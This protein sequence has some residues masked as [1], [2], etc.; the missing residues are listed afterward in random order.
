MN[1]TPLKQIAL[2]FVISLAGGL[3]AHAQNFTVESVGSVRKYLTAT[4]TETQVHVVFSKPVSSVTGPVAGN[5][6]ISGGVTVTAAQLIT[7][8]PAA[9]LQDVAQNPTPFGR[10]FD[11]E[12]VLL[13]VTGLAADATASITITGVT[14]EAGDALPTTVVNFK[15]SGYTWVDVGVHSI[16][17][18]VIAVSTNGFDV[19]SSGGTQWSDEDQVTLVY[20]NVTGD[21]DINARVEFQDFSSRWGRA[22]LMAREVLNAAEDGATQDTTASRYANAHANPARCW[23]DTATAGLVTA[24]NQFESHFREIQGGE[25]GSAAGG[26]PLFPDAWVR[27]QRTGETIITHR[28]DNGTDW[29][30]MAQRQVSDPGPWN[31]SLF[32]GFGYAP[33]IGNINAANPADAKNRLFLA[34]YRFGKIPFPSSRFD[35]NPTGLMITVT[36]AETAADPATAVLKING[37]TVTASAS[38][39]GNITTVSYTQPN[40]FVVG[41]TNLAELTINTTTGLPVRTQSSWVAAYGVI[42]ASYALA[43]PATGPGMN[44][45]THLLDTTPRSPG[46]QNNS[47]AAEQQILGGYIDPTTGLPY[48][49]L[50]SPASGA[51]PTGVV[52]WEQFGGDIDVTPEDGPDNFNTMRPT[53][54]PIPNDLTPGVSSIDPNW[55][56]VEVLT[57]L[58][59]S[60]GAYRMGVNSDDGFLVSAGLDAADRFGVPLGIFNAG[61]GASDTTFDFYVSANG[62]YPFRLL[63]WEGNGGASAEW[64]AVNLTTGEKTLINGVPAGAVKAYQTGAGRAHVKS[65]LPGNGFTGV[66]ATPT[67]K[68]DFANGTTSVKA[69]SVSL[70]VDGNTVLSAQSGPS[71]SWTSP[72]ALGYATTHSGSIIWTE[73]TVPETVWTNNFTFAIQPFTPDVLPPG[74][75]W[76]ESEDYNYGSGQTVAA[77][78]VMP[79]TGDAYSGLEGVV[80]VDFNDVVV[81][82]GGI[83][84]YRKPFDATSQTIPVA[85]NTAGRFGVDRPGTVDMVTNYKIGWIGSGD[86]YN[87][88]RT[89]PPGTYNAFAALS[90]DAGTM[91]ARLELVT[92]PANVPNQTLQVLGTF[93]GP[94]SGAWSENNLLAMQAPDGSPAVFKIRGAAPTTFRFNGISGDID[95][96]VVSPAQGVP[97]KVT[98]AT[99]A[100]GAA[101]PRDSS[102]SF[103]IEDFTTTVAPANVRLFLDNVNVTS[104]ATIQKPA[105]IMTITYAPGQM[106]VGSHTYRLEFTDSATVTRT[107]EATFTADVRGTTGQFLIEAEDFDHGGGQSVA[108]AS[109]MPYTGNAYNGLGAT[110]DVDY[111]STETLDA[112]S[113]WTPVYRT[114][115]PITAGTTAPLNDNLGGVLGRDRAGNWQMTVNYKIGWTGAGDWYNYSRN[116][117]AGSYEVWAALSSGDAG[118]P[119]RGSLSLVNGGTATSLGVFQAPTTGGWGL[120]TLVPMQ[121]PTTNGVTQVVNLG[122]QQTLRFF[123]DAGDFDYFLLVPATAQIQITGVSVAAGQLT[124][125]WTGGGTLYSTPNLG[126]SPISWTTTGD[127]DGSYT[128]PV[129]A[130]NL[131]FRVQGP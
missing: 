65:L 112:A 84:E 89:V 92:S 60:Q 85:V 94:A 25:T 106:T 61:R 120:N 59:L 88:T 76:I 41:S 32:V 123:T 38:K 40:P 109:T 102:L 128:A 37:A 64:F 26:V 111:H 103:T 69:G 121:G 91:N 78:S 117:Q 62:Y 17:G 130:G 127:S 131:F 124:V 80:G 43:A 100:A 96:F 39:V 67:I 23:S 105:D 104:G 52:N 79:Y 31:A 51:V 34:Q 36:D 70:V 16:P 44:Y 68:V 98:S 129:G 72:T 27:L 29:T 4:T 48:V 90:Q 125:T 35:W 56:T 97:A 30:E 71:V 82:G 22:G 118:V 5:Y 19:F 46:D 101:V 73:T 115:A 1:R 57:Y 7:G 74:S 95:W 14:S 83:V 77:A 10:V 50:A 3:V 55:F 108:G 122:G 18:K 13:T 8:L 116:I 6:T 126:A 20:K 24:N 114:G 58:N 11:N 86:W 12:C 45:N 110:F 113:G 9:T 2:A 21:F 54:T 63:Y 93:T 66:S 49:N 75:F 42:P 53:A 28:S 33:E 107:N 119:L 81:A 15:D 99:P 87:Y 47:G